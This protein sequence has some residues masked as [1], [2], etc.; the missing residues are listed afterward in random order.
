MGNGCGTPGHH[1]QHHV[2]WELKQGH[3]ILAL[4][5]FMQGCPVKEVDQKLKAVKVCKSTMLAN[6]NIILHCIFLS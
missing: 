3:K 5:H 2:G 1:A 4:H 6:F